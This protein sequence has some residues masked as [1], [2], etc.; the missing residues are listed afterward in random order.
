MGDELREKLR[1]AEAECRMMMMGR[2][3]DHGDKESRAS[4]ERQALKENK[5]K[6]VED[7]KGLIQ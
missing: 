4:T 5:V 2:E 6:M 3:K 7:M 1:E